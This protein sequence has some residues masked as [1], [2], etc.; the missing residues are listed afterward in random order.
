[1]LV[2]HDDQ[3]VELGMVYRLELATMPFAVW[4]GDRFV[5]PRERFRLRLLE[6]A[7]RAEGGFVEKVGGPISGILLY[8]ELE[9]DHCQTCDWNVSP[10]CK[11]RAHKIVQE[12][13]P[14]RDL[15]AA[16]DEITAPWLEAAAEARCKDEADEIMIRAFRWEMAEGYLYEPSAIETVVLCRRLH[17]LGEDDP[18][19]AS[20]ELHFPN[21][22]CELQ[23]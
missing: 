21:L 16:I 19:R 11:P 9:V 7:T 2:E 17:Q 1:M 10:G 23:A 14:N 3:R 18:E 4:N 13:A 15:L 6:T 22:T 5:G 12:M 8:A 20:I